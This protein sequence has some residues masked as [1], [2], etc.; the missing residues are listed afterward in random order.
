[1]SEQIDIGFDTPKSVKDLPAERIHR[2]HRGLMKADGIGYFVRCLLPVTLRNGPRI[3]IGLWLAISKADYRE[4]RRVWDDNPKYQHLVV[5]GAV[6][7]VI[8]PWS[9]ALGCDV[10]AEVFDVESLPVIT[11]SADP[12]VHR[13]LTEQWDPDQVLTHFWFPLPVPVREDLGGGWSIE[14]SAG[15]EKS[16]DDRTLLFH[17]A[18]RE[19]SVDLFTE[20]TECSP[21]E[22][23]Q[24][25]AS[26]LADHPLTQKLTVRSGDELR[27]GRWVTVS[28]EDASDG[29]EKHMLYGQVFHHRRI[30]WLVCTCTDSTDR[31]WAEHV[32]R[33]VRTDAARR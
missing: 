13:M 2:A 5:R 31:P 1:M 7:N 25:I 3:V 9:D 14:R 6:A 11:A 21:E 18:R 22:S 32:F 12:L 8:D 16:S 28:A 20:R 33:S 30:L 24:V 29:V 26:G 23:L 17:D 27:Q 19:V 4:C 15:L 10:T